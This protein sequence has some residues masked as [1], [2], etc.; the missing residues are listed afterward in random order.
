MKEVKLVRLADLSEE[1]NYWH[2]PYTSLF[3]GRGQQGRGQ[4]AKRDRPA[5][6]RRLADMLNE[7]WRIEGTGGDG[8]FNSFVILVRERQV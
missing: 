8:L 2:E 6:E 5:V 4:Q 3:E 7:G 1:G